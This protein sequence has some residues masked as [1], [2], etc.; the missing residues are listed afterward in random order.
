MLAHLSLQSLSL[1]LFAVDGAGFS[2]A[3]VSPLSRR[4]LVLGK[5]AAEGLLTTG[6]ALLASGV[7]M[8]LEP[9][10]L[11]FWPAILLAGVALSALLAPLHAWI[12]MFFPKAVDLGRLGKQAQPN[13]LA[14]LAGLFATAFAVPIAVGP[15]LLAFVVTRRLWL[16]TGVELAWA[17]LALV[18]ARFLLGLA[19]RTL[20]SREEAIYLALAEGS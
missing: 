5:A 16:A 11:P 19:A 6:L 3:L 20:A 4:D 17:A 12:S 15:G 18:A 8:T 10:A 14:G 1:N 7:V 9:A 2:L 13:Q